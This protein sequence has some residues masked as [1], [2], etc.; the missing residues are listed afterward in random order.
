M[1][2]PDNR[3]K[4]IRAA[5][6]TTFQHGFARTSL[7]DIAKE[8]GVPL[9]NVYYYFKTKEA[10]GEAIIDDRFAQ[11][12]EAHNSW[13]ANDSPKE[14]LCAFVDSVLANRDSLARGGCSIGTLC[15]ELSKERGPLAK[16]AAGLLRDHLLW[17]EKQFGLLGK[18]R[19]S[20]NLAV[21]L[22]AALQGV[23]VLAHS[24]SDPDLVVAET[25]RLREWIQGL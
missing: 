2:L 23:G 6:K 15:S 13:E 22:L 4:L 3:T 7:A 25:T 16:K 17:S 19:D 5:R 12:R 1:P 8:S 10:I 11:V 18:G 24:L 9:G 20:Y 21:H 14:R